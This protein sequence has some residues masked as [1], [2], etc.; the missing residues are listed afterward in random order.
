MLLLFDIGYNPLNGERI[1]ERLRKYPPDTFDGLSFKDVRN[2]L[3]HVPYERLER[4][5]VTVS[6]PDMR[7]ASSRY[8]QYL[9]TFNGEE[10]YLNHND[11]M[12]FKRIMI[13]V[14]R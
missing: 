9:G 5:T 10:F 3:K 2:F 8:V 4:F 14:A 7:K 1:S 12:R 11:Y 6:T 13:S